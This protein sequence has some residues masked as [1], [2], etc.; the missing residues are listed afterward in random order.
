MI[1]SDLFISSSFFSIRKKDGA[2]ESDLSKILYDKMLDT[3]HPERK[4]E[5]LLGRL[6]AS[7]AHE[8]CAGRELLSLE[9]NKDRSPAWPSDVVGSI[10]HN[11]DWVGAAVAKSSDLLGVGI[12]FEVRKRAKLALG[13][14]IRHAE[15]LKEHADFSQEELLTFIFSC[16]ESLYKALYPTVKNFFGFQAAAVKEINFQDKTFLI[17]LMTQLTPNLGPS[18]RYSFK[19]RFFMDDTSYLTVLEIPLKE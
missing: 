12:D 3:Y 19:G 1:P 14:Q 13:N 8:L 18:K 15:D 4:K 7:K 16:K 2:L 9:A 5:F 11:E 17:E 6:C 10:S